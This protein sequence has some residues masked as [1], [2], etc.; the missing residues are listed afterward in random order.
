MRRTAVFAALL[1]WTLAA[2]ADV[3]FYTQAVWAEL[4][5]WN[6]Q[7]GTPAYTAQVL[8]NS[9]SDRLTPT[10]LIYNGTPPTQDY[11]VDA[12]AQGC[13]PYP[14]SPTTWS[15]YLRVS[16][17]NWYEVRMVV[18]T[19]SDGSWLQVQVYRVASGVY[20]LLAYTTS[21]CVYDHYKSTIAGSNITVFIAGSNVLSVSDA[22][23][24]SGN[25]GLGSSNFTYYTYFFATV[26]SYADIQP[27]SVPTGLNAAALYSDHVNLAWIASTD[28]VAVTGYKVYRGG[29]Y[30]GTSSGTSYTDV[31]VDY[32]TN[33]SYTVSALDAAGNESSQ[34]AALP[35]HTPAPI[36]AAPQTGAPQEFSTTWG[37]GP[38]KITMLTGAL[39][40]RIPLPRLQH[41]TAGPG[42]QFVASHNSQFWT[43]D[44]AGTK[45]NALDVGYGLNWLFQIAAVYPVFSGDT[46]VRYE[47]QD[48]SG[49][50]HKLLPTG[51]AHVYKTQDSSYL[52]W[53]DDAS[54]YPTLT[55]RDGT[56]WQFGCVSRYPEPESGSRYPTKL[57]DR[58]G[59]QITVTY[60][61]AQGWTGTNTSARIT[62]I[63]DSQTTYS[64]TY[65]TVSGDPTNQ[66]H[67]TQVYHYKNGQYFVDAQFTYSTNTGIVSPFNQPLSGQPITK[68]LLMQIY[69]TGSPGPFVF[70]YNTSAE[71]TKITFP[72]KGYFRYAYATASF[73]SG[74][75]QIREISTRYM[76]A[77][78]STEQTYTFS[79]PDEPTLS[80][81]TQTKVADPPGNSKIWFFI[82]G[83]SPGWDNGL[84]ACL[85]TYQGSGA[86]ASCGATPT[87]GTL[88]RRVD[89][90]WTQ[91]NPASG[92]LTNPRITSTTGT[93]EDNTTQ[94]RT[95]QDVDSSGNV[96]TVREY[97][98]GNLSTPYRSITT[99]YMSGGDYTTRNILNLP[100]QVKVYEG[101]V[102][103]TLK[104]TTTY[105]YTT[106]GTYPQ[107]TPQ[108]DQS[109][110]SVFRPRVYQ[111]NKDGLVT[112]YSADAGGNVTGATDPL[113]HT[114]SSAGY[115]STTGYTTLASV[116]G[117]GNTTT[118]T[119]NPDN[120]P[121]SETGSNGDTVSFNYNFYRPMRV[122][123]PDGTYTSYA[124]SDRDGGGYPIN[125]PGSWTYPHVS[126]QTSYLGKV[127][128]TIIDGFGRP[129]FQMVRETASPVVWI[130]T[131]T[132]YTACSCSTTGKSYRTSRPYKSD[133]SGTPLS[134]HNYYW[135]TSTFDALG[136]PT[137]VELPDGNKTTY[138]YAVENNATWKGTLTKVTPPKLITDPTGKPKRYLND[139]FGRLLRVEEPKADLTLAKTAEYTFDVMG[140]MTQART[141]KRDGSAYQTR[142]FVYNTLGQLT[143]ATNPENGTVTYTYN[144][145]GLLATKTDAKS[146]VLYFFYDTKHRLLRIESP[147]GTV[148]TEF[149]YDTGTYGVGKMATASNDG[150]TWRYSYDVMGR[151]TTQTLQAPIWNG[152]NQLT[153]TAQ[154]GFDYDGQLKDLYYPGFGYA[155]PGGSVTPGTHYQYSY[156]AVGRPAGLQYDAGGWQT[157]AQNA[158]YNAA[159]QITSWQESA[160]GLTTL[161][162][163]YDAAR[164]WI[165]NINAGGFINLTYNYLPDG[166]VSSVTDSVNPG[167]SASYSYDELNRLTA[168]TTPN[169]GLAF[170]YDDFGN[171]LTQS[172]TGGSPPTK[173]LAYDNNN[174]ITTSGYSYDSNGNLTNTPGSTTLQYDVF[175]RLT[176]GPLVGEYYPWYGY[177][178]FGRRVWRSAEGGIQHVYFYDPGGR[179]LADL[180]V[181]GQATTYQYFAGQ[182]LNQYT[183]RVG[184]VRYDRYVGARHYYPYGEEITSTNS[185]TYKFAQLHRDGDTGLDYA[186]NRYYSSGQGRFLTPDPSPATKAK[187]PKSWNAYSYAAGDPVNLRDTQ[188]LE[189]GAVWCWQDPESE[190]FVCIQVGDP[191][192]GG[193]RPQPVVDPPVDSGAGPYRPR[194]GGI[195]DPTLQKVFDKAFDVGKKKLEKTAC[196]DL[197]SKTPGQASNAFA[198]AHYDNGVIGD[199]SRPSGI[200]PTTTF[201]VANQQSQT[202]TINVNGYF[203]GPR[204]QDLGNNISL[205]HWAGVLY[206]VENISDADFRAYVLLHEL[207]HLTGALPDENDQARSDEFNR[208]ILRKCFGKNPR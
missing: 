138:A 91:D 92:D 184:T 83:S 62:S 65:S 67:V 44:A 122:N 195:S 90:T 143:S 14:S 120:T 172:A 25:L 15:H 22:S 123:K 203:F 6:I 168:A 163:T 191:G 154:Y 97:A 4:N 104:S 16:G 70:E 193:P 200:V 45:M 3:T 108:W 71:V 86:A 30:L 61:P 101:A 190:A 111:V 164:G 94:S 153:A 85:H 69:F 38:E 135:T 10:R 11:S 49:V 170:T 77:D 141:F 162:R 150:H 35:V 7:A 139:A 113:Y 89:H 127:S 133:A 1:A 198:A 109:Y 204:Y 115:D 181:G 157:V 151:V 19:N 180:V 34:S 147:Q 159:G 88:L 182:R 41:R 99:S 37:A 64:W 160:P 118:F 57:T 60:G 188:G 161:T 103:G 2:H 137:Q 205:D 39:G 52:V 202:V 13:A 107:G 80:Q 112:T 201:A 23:Y 33:Y 40:I 171:R 175:D 21:S 117:G 130:T 72:Y 58:F 169:W 173:T 208:D 116:T 136:R 144:G 114:V 156:D 24:A 28:N 79:H 158:Q 129:L 199:L 155:A 196:A 9:S 105:S 17:S 56:I 81:H 27:P 55:F 166:R 126:T 183:D 145:D 149:T 87:S 74:A 110:A 186:V 75:R 165:T 134:G 93:L 12:I 54:P 42:Y 59:N 119:T 53:K 84:L 152:Q 66:P 106:G 142:T 197:F 128:K 51:T 132:E 26:L 102:T 95:E 174:R 187:Q 96:T 78:T 29:A 140:R 20:T 179:L 63:L 73:S 47:L 131:K 194:L 177:D 176:R 31:T 207:A 148:K 167:Q 121:N 98:Y 5:N 48:G 32:A 206:G 50:V 76:S 18:P 125:P 68:V 43:W 124:Y 189:Y 8:F 46:L 82:N 146:Q 185:D 178:A 100:Y 192:E 36:Y